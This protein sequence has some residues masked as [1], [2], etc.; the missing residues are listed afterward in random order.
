MCIIHGCALYTGKYSISKFKQVVIILFQSI[1][2]GSLL[3]THFRLQNIA[4]KCDPPWENQQKSDNMGTSAI[5][6]HA[7]VTTDTDM[8]IF[9]EKTESV[10]EAFVWQDITR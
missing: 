9:N 2:I 6:R 5:H 8:C 10:T 4:V 7:S 3:Q 1:L